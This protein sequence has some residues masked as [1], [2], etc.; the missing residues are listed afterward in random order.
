MSRIPV[1]V[2]LELEAELRERIA[3]VDERIELLDP[4]A[5]LA[6]AEVVLLGAMPRDVPDALRDAIRADASRVRW[7]HSNWAGAGEQV[8]AAELTADE[9]EHVAITTSA[10]IHATPLAEFTLLGLLAFAKDLPRLERDKAERRWDHYPVGELRG[11]TVLVLGLGGIGREVVRLASAF[12]MRTL[13]I[14][15][16]PGDVPHLD[17]LHP[18]ERLGELLPRADALVV[19]LPSTKA[20]R[21]LVDGAALA[22]LPR[23]A[24]VV[25]VGRGA[26]VNEDALVAALRDGRL[27]GAALDVY[28]QEPLPPESPLW[29]LPNV[30]LAPHT[31]ALSVHENE[32]VVELFSDNLRRYL[33]GDPLRNRVDPGHYY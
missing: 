18:P 17:E 27:A 15:R 30:L 26:V 10:G 13:G 23:G 12:G 21:G 9:L 8:A 6:E 16:T 24:I 5:P 29:E 3:A 11:R 31:M 7:I 1:A 19:A 33:R 32:R 14:K 20:T 4:S 28:A 22:L 25:N 2:T